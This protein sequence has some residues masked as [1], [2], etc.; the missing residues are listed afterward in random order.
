M[1]AWPAFT[2]GI[3]AQDN[4]L[5]AMTLVDDILSHVFTQHD[6]GWKHPA[7]SL[8]MLMNRS[9]EERD[10]IGPEFAYQSLQDAA[11]EIGLW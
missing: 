10:K 8:G 5:G 2:L 3:H 1:I 4:A 9:W 11:V 6:A 7:G